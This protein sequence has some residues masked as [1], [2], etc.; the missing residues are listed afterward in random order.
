MPFELELRKEGNVP[1]GAASQRVRMRNNIPTIIVSSAV[2]E[3]GHI[4]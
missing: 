4:G 1:A 2:A 3:R